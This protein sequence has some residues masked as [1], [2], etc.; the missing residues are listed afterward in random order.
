M[1]DK[2]NEIYR[3]GF[4]DGFDAGRKESYPSWP[5]PPQWWPPVQLTWI[6]GPWTSDPPNF[7]I[8][9]GTGNTTNGGKV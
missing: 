3:Q 9:D 1:T 4:K 7:T 8:S 2:E 6:G 5:T